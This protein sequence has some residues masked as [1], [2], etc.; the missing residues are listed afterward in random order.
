MKKII[1]ALALLAS[2]QVANAQQQKDAD[3]AVKKVEA[4]KAATLNEKKAANMATW[5][6]LGQVYVDAYNAVQGN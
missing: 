4:A 5:L 6:K 2:V 3:A 1:F